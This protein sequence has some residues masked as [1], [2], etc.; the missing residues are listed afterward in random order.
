MNHYSTRLVTE[1]TDLNPNYNPDAKYVTSVDESWPIAHI[2][3][4]LIVNVFFL[5]VM[6][7]VPTKICIAL[8]V[9]PNGFRQLLI[10]IKNEYGNPP[11]VVT[12]NGYADNGVI[13]DLGRIDYIKVF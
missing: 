11:I 7:L 4:W 12:E 8:Q 6:L 10:W 13:N 5:F 9:V 2:V 1:G 3:P